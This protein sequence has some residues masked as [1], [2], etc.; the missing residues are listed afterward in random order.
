MRQLKFVLPMIAA[1]LAVPASAQVLA[2]DDL[3]LTDPLQMLEDDKVALILFRGNVSEEGEL[4]IAEREVFLGAAPTPLPDGEAVD[5]ESRLQVALRDADNT[6]LDI[7]EFED[8][9]LGHI[10]EADTH[11]HVAQETAQFELVVP[12]LQGTQSATISR[13]GDMELEMSS[14]LS[15]SLFE[16]RRN[17]AQAQNVAVNV[18]LAADVASFC[19]GRTLNVCGLE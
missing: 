9:R 6:L 13:E 1:V 5:A 11:A 10:I 19:E 15:A 12:L 3:P 16:S 17:V 18:D 2:S 8:P 7:Q 4:E 14:G